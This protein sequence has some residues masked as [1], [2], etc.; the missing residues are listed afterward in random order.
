M[1]GPLPAEFVRACD[2]AG[3]DAGYREALWQLQPWMSGRTAGARIEQLITDFGH[4]RLYQQFR[5]G[6]QDAVVRFERYWRVA[7]RRY[8]GRGFSAQQVDD[9]TSAFFTKLLLKPLPYRFDRPFVAY[10]RVV[11]VNV[12]R[13]QVR[14]VRRQLERE[15]ALDDATAPG[16]PADRLPSAEPNA[17]QQVIAAEERRRIEAALAELAPVDRHI[18]Y[19][20]LVDGASGDELAAALGMTRPA[21]YQRLYRARKKLK[22]LL[23]GDAAGGRVRR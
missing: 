14:R 23:A 18:V 3:V 13:D 1:P 19:A 15:V 7:A 11:L 8:L 22:K 4:W 6:D 2:R 9:L 5:A 12:S 17:E 16:E 10:L 21:V 20:S